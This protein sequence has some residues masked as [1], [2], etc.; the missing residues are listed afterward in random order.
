M[1]STIVVYG[2]S[3]G[4]RAS[5]TDALGW[6]SPS[7]LLFSKA[8]KRA[9]KN[10]LYDSSFQVIFWKSLRLTLCEKCPNTEYF[11]VRIFPHSDWIRRDNSYFSVFSPNAGKHGPENT[12]YLNI[13]HTVWLSNSK[14]FI[15][16][17]RFHLPIGG[18]GCWFLTKN[19]SKKR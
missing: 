13:F 5:W 7:L 11:P 18:R 6:P 3:H 8:T 2:L 17:Y 1:K 16:I 14:N 19:F 10:E 4:G 12:P 9:I 15:K